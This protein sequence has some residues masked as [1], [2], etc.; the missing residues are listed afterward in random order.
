MTSF[1]TI[2]SYLENLAAQ[3][4]AVATAFRWNKA[5]LA[6]QLRQGTAT[7]IV[8]I[9]APETQEEFTN[10]KVFNSHSCAL[11]VLGKQ[12]VT[13]FKRDDYAAQNEIL[14]HCQRICFEMA[15]RIK[16]DASTG[17]VPWL[18]GLVVK[19]SFHYF[20]VGPLFSNAYYGYRVEF[21]IKSKVGCVVDVAKWGDLP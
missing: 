13:A 17:R 11:T 12:G 10:T 14:D 19:G 20:K 1:E 2:I 15:A 9:D 4:V 21:T 6:G 3:H 18:R 16:D 7:S 5:Q 8:L